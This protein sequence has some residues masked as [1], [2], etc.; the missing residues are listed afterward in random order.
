MACWRSNYLLPSPF[1]T[2]SFPRTSLINN[3]FSIIWRTFMLRWYFCMLVQV[4][5]IE[6]NG[7]IQIKNVRECDLVVHKIKEEEQSSIHMKNYCGG[8]EVVKHFQN[9]ANK[10][11]NWNN[12]SRGQFFSISWKQCKPC[13][14]GISLPRICS[15]EIIREAQK[16]WNKSVPYNICVSFLF[17]FL[18]L[19]LI[20]FIIL[21]L[22]VLNSWQLIIS[23]SK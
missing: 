3:I 1:G 6:M 22:F 19:F 15:K 2:Y 8:Q 12:N 5:F 14:P 7:T 16:N 9:K 20:F 17:L 10:D 13:V 11:L 23:L 18:C 4:S 21:L